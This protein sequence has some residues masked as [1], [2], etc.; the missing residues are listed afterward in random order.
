MEVRLTSPGLWLSCSGQRR[1]SGL[2]FSEVVSPSSSPVNPNRVGF[3]W[4]HGTECLKAITRPSGRF[5]LRSRS[6][7]ISSTPYHRRGGKIRK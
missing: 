3:P 6:S 5:P 7:L 2:A 4:N 1:G